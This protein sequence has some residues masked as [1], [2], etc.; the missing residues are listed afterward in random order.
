MNS[1]GKGQCSS[2]SMTFTCFKQRFE[3]TIS[4]AKLIHTKSINCR[5][6][7][8]SDVQIELILIEDAAIIDV[9][10][11]VLLYLYI[12]KENLNKTMY[13]DLVQ[14]SSQWDEGQALQRVSIQVP[15]LRPPAKDRRSMQ[16]RSKA[17]DVKTGQEM[18]KEKSQH[19]CHR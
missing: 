1:Y 7:M 18:R 17:R 5:E 9:Y 15:K 14:R 4:E 3:T 11:E 19:D 6:V 12:Y 8:L 2:A 10:F 13:G 16:Q